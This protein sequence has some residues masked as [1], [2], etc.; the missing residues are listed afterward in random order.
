MVGASHLGAGSGEWHRVSQSET[1]VL[2]TEANV[3][4]AESKWPCSNGGQSAASMRIEWSLASLSF[5]VQ[6]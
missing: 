2:L 6:A 3:L 4:G 1:M 5:L